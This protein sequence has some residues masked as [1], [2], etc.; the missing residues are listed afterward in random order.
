MYGWEGLK[1]PE[2][3]DHGDLIHQIIRSIPRT[4]GE[5]RHPSIVVAFAIVKD[6]RD[7]RHS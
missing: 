5:G 3:N 7:I 1:E 4:V 2:M 6:S